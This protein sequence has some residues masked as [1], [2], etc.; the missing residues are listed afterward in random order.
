M[1]HCQDLHPSSCRAARRA[2][3]WHAAGWVFLALSCVAG[4]AFV[5]AKFL[6]ILP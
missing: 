3:F 2:R 6:G 1:N 4:L 5:F